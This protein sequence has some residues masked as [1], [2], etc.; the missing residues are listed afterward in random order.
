MS[1]FLKNEGIHQ[2]AKEA[3]KLPVIVE[4][5]I[6]IR[7]MDKTGEEDEKIKILQKELEQM[8]MKNKK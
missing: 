4:L 1:S 3:T 8:Q 2:Y 7:I 6:R 5:G